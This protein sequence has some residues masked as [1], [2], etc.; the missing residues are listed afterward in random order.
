MI[1][2]TELARS[3]NT[4]GDILYGLINLR[5]DGQK[6]VLAQMKEAGAD[7]DLWDSYIVPFVPTK[8]H[9]A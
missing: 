9:K 3:V 6:L 4:D 7:K 8:K 1:F 2:S 5:S